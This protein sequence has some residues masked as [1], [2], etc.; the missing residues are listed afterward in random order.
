MKKKR[1]ALIFMDQCPTHPQDL[2]TFN[3]MKFVFFP[4]NFASKSQPFDLSV[5]RCAK[6]H[7]IKTLI[8][9]NTKRAVKD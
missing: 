4:S 2:S 3:N 6:V 7:Y 1:E 9:P 5:I 8:R